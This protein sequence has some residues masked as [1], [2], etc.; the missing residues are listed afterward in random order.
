MTR[1]GV[2]AESY[3][4][5]LTNKDDGSSRISLVGRFR[6]HHLVERRGQMTCFEAT[7][8]WNINGVFFFFRDFTRIGVAEMIAPSCSSGKELAC[9]CGRRGLN[10]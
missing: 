7:Y 5:F 10:P 6:S 4:D 2:R 9:Q 3:S 8:A 1:D